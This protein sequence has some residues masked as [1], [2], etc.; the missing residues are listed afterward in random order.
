MCNIHIYEENWCL[1]SVEMKIIISCT[2]N[3]MMFFLSRKDRE[4]EKLKCWWLQRLN[5]LCWSECV[6]YKVRGKNI[7]FKF[8]LKTK[9]GEDI[10]MYVQYHRDTEKSGID[11]NY[12]VYVENVDFF[13]FVFLRKN[14]VYIGYKRVHSI[15]DG[16]AAGIFFF[17]DKSFWNLYLIHIFP[18]KKKQIKRIQFL[19]LF[20][21]V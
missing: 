4:I 11:W 19:F 1:F 6:W 18:P 17:F 13:C 3:Q 20:D 21:S 12:H 8:F 10:K 5:W 15:Y 9:K 14:C 2:Y 16:C 7:I